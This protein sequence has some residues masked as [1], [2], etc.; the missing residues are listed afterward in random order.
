MRNCYKILLF[1]L[2]ITA[3]PSFTS[4]QRFFVESTSGLGYFGLKSGTHYSPNSTD[5]EKPGMVPYIPV[6]FR[7]GGGFE[8][9]QLYYGMSIFATQAKYEFHDAFDESIK[10]TD[11]FKLSNNVLGLRFNFTGDASDMAS[12]LMRMGVGYSKLSFEESNEQQ[13]VTTNQSFKKNLMYDLGAGLHIPVGDFLS[14]NISYT[15]NHIRFKS[16]EFDRLIDRNKNGVTPINTHS[17]ELGFSLFVG[18]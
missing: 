1:S 15:Y 8:A 11:R 16:N 17:L 14:I 2:F 13:T 10:V 12:F 7:I 5:E 6:N 4:A 3:L 18:G 9:V